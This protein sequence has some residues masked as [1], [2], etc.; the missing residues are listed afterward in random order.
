MAVVSFYTL[1]PTAS[2]TQDQ[3]DD[4]TSENIND[5]AILGTDYI[6]EI[7]V[8]KLIGS[9]IFDGFRLYVRKQMHKKVGDF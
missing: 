9:N 6:V 8:A 3:I 2:I 7:E 5:M 4:S 1:V